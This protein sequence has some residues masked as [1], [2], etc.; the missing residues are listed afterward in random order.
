MSKIH[1]TANSMNVFYNLRRNNRVHLVPDIDLPILNDQPVLRIII[2]GERRGRYQGQ[3]FDLDRFDHSA[4]YNREE[5]RIEMHLVARE[6]HRVAIDAIDLTVDFSKG[7]SIRTEISCKYTQAMVEA[8]LE[9]AGLRM[10]RWDTD[11]NHFFA[12]SLSATLH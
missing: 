4:F 5:S 12:L 6:S 3:I 1:L 11:T 10:T 8:M 2:L 7:E 9:K